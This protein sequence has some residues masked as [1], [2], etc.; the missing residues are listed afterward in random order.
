MKWLLIGHRGT[1]KTSLLRRLES[2]FPGVAAFDLDQEI[3]RKVGM[4]VSDYFESQGEVCFRQ[5]E[6][7][8]LNDLHHKNPSYIIACGAGLRLESVVSDAE[9]I[10]IRRYT[11]KLGRVFLDRP[12]LHKDIGPLDEYMHRFRERNI[13]YQKHATEIIDI[14][15]GFDKENEFEKDFFQQTFDLSD[16]AVTLQAY[17]FR[18]PETLKSYIQKRSS[19]DLTIELRDDLLTRE[20]IHHAMHFIPKDQ[21]LISFRQKDPNK[22]LVQFAI[23]NQIEWDWDLDLGEPPITPPI[24]SLHQCKNIHEGLERLSQYPDSVQKA[25]FMIQ[26]LEDLLIGDEWLRASL[27]RAF[28][29]RSYDGSYKWYRLYRSDYQAIQ[30]LADQTNS[31]LDQPQLLEVLRQQDYKKPTNFAAVLGKPVEHSLSPGAHTDFFS[32]YNI[33]FYAVPLNEFNISALQKLGLIT[34]AVTSPFKNDAY[35]SSE[36]RSP[37]A[38]ELK[39]VNTLV[40]KEKISGY[41]TDVIGLKSTLREAIGPVV[42]WGGGAMISSILKHLPEAFPYSSRNGLPKAEPSPLP[43]RTIV[44]SVGRENFQAQGVLPPSEWHPSLVIDM[45]YTDD[46]F[47]KL[48][49]Q[50]VKAKY[51]SGMTLFLEQA[52]KQ[53]EIWSKHLS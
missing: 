35:L 22:L 46:S 43:P 33:P 32:E 41:N 10:W 9:K 52:K 14:P 19:W 49:A 31:Q 38:E 2:Y 40:I 39:S 7:Q 53:Q 42:I 29:P 26:G 3:S 47:G 11:D 18:T 27:N 34:A 5:M 51:I 23:N 20:Q 50:S 16:W 24:V 45:N 21:A 25:A 4:P 44:W 13:L 37:E 28:L 6:L 8:T 15:E 12:R 48:Y 17:H 1:G 36:V 30:F